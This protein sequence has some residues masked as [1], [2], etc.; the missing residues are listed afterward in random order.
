MMDDSTLKTLFGMAKTQL[1]RYR[2]DGLAS[3]IVEVQTLAG[4]YGRRM[5]SPPA[6]AD[7]FGKLNVPPLGLR[8]AAFEAATN[9]GRM[10]WPEDAIEPLPHPIDNEVD[11]AFVAGVGAGI[12]WLL[13]A[14]QN[15]GSLRFRLEEN[16]EAANEH[17][18]ARLHRL[19]RGEDA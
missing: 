2:E 13:D 15:D 5:Y 8:R 10:E 19:A 11:K 16:A 6:L 9:A 1:R 18:A 17:F 7:F 12:F 3:N 4:V 14:M